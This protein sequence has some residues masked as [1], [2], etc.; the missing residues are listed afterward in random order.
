MAN[1]VQE[2][3]RSRGR[4]DSPLNTQASQA[5]LNQVKPQAAPASKASAAGEQ[6][7]T[8][9]DSQTIA[10]RRAEKKAAIQAEES[11]DNRDQEARMDKVAEIASRSAGKNKMPPA[12][13]K[14][15]KANNAVKAANA[16]ADDDDEGFE[17]D[18]ENLE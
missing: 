10:K 1:K 15:P 11:A 17:D 3:S 8:L 18:D 6:K 9:E 7:K 5:T 4:G 16:A 12:M 13:S 14:A 2:R